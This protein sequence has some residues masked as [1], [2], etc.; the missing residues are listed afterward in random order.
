MAPRGCALALLPALS[1]VSCKARHESA[2]SPAGSSSP[3][4]QARARDAIPA[5]SGPIE[6]NGEWSEPD[7]SKRALREQFLGDDGQLA[8]PSS[9]VRWLHDESNLYVGLYA[10]DDNMLSSDAFDLT[11]GKVQMR[12]DAAGTVTPDITGVRVG[13]DRDGTLDEPSNYDEEWVLEIAIPLA[14][15]GLAV[16][17]YAEVKAS[18]CDLPKNGTKRCGQWA[19]KLTLE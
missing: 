17:T 19:G 3:A 7:W 2:S 5:I 8:R 13:I 16:G 14:Q 9:E 1:S 10:A 6:V 11:V 12:I 4:E 15:V 18:R